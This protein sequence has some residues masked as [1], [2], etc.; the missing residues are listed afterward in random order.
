MRR[1]A[2][3]SVLLFSL[4]SLA[5]FVLG[6][7][8]VEAGERA[9]P[10]SKRLTPKEEALIALG[11]RLFFDPV[12][13][14]SGARSCASCH[15]PEHGFSDP[16]RISD[17]DLG[18]TRRHSQTLLDSHLNPSA[19]WDGEFETIEEL[20]LARIGAIRGRKGQLGHGVS[21]ADVI[22][23][24]LSSTDGVELTQ[25]TTGDDDE[26]IDE[27]TG[28]GGGDDGGGSYGG[29][30]RSRTSRGASSANPSSPRGATPESS[31]PAGGGCAKCGPAPGPAPGVKDPGEGGGSEGAQGAPATPDSG[32]GAA[33]DAGP[34]DA[35]AK[36]E[37]EAPKDDDARAKDD[38]GKAAVAKEAKEDK[39]SEAELKRRAD[40]LRRALRKLPLA[41]D[42]LQEG[43]RYDEAFAAAFG[44]S[45]VNTARIARAIAAYCRTL[46]STT[47]AYDRYVA[48]ESAALSAEAQRGLALFKGR[49]ACATCHS[50]EGE[51]PTF[52]DFQFHNTGVVWNSLSKDQRAR[53][54]A[55]DQTF[56]RRHDNLELALGA[57]E[58]RARRSTRKADIRSFKTP[59]LRDVAKRGPFMHDGRFKTLTDVVAYY[60]RG[61]SPDPTKASHIKAFDANKQDLADL[62]AFMEALSGDTR[63]GL[64]AKA[65]RE[66][67][68]K[69]RL[70]LVDADGKAL[71]D[72]P[73]RLSTVGDLAHANAGYATLPG[74]RRTDARGW[75][76]FT[77]RRTTHT[78]VT[79]PGGLV[80]LQ[81]ALVP[82]SCRQAKVRVPVRGRA[83]LVVHFPA[84]AKPPAVLAA[85]HVGTLV[86][87]G[88]DVPR[89]RFTRGKVLELG[90]SQVVRYSGWL[91]TD[92]PPT[93]NV[94]IPGLAETH[95]EVV[96][97]RDTPA[98]LDLTA[99]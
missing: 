62:V 7:P 89:T 70:R 32:G 45:K 28:G 86:L 78:R 74:V 58:G 95:S 77:N 23:Q 73:V 79:L 55:H 42:L 54:A 68:P 99:R 69:T 53:L 94:R 90:R 4:L 14:R 67:A 92:V 19:H 38:Q 37:K 81:G 10:S 9:A 17:D 43:G 57:D 36:D 21:L 66:R 25:E 29:A 75:V 35:K 96:L 34:Y 48:G 87:P 26:F 27:G 40:A 47:S 72:M 24:Q 97:D 61:A 65:W 30:E 6:Q 13:S 44:N 16:A 88:H 3:L 49:A 51:H 84:G 82:D 52:T 18:R 15:D 31:G 46:E 64:P 85:E 91:R 76:E 5:L 33:P 59:T 80:P 20:V 22:A 1:F 2:S 8:P 83:E 12:V 93:V 63:P 11:R 41:Q 56:R 39:P 98:R 50:I 71:A 60:A